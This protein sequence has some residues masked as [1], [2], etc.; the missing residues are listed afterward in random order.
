MDGF[1]FDNKVAIVTGGSSGMGEATARLMTTNGLTGA[2]LVG[3]DTERGNAVAADLTQAGCTSVFVAADLAEV[4]AIEQIMAAASAFERLDVLVNVAGVSD[5]NTLANA[6]TDFFDR[7]VAINVRA[8]YFLSQAA[9]ERMRQT[10]GGAIVNVGSVAGYAGEPKISVYSI[11]KAALR[12]MT[13]V[14]AQ[15]LRSDRIRVNQVNPG[16]SETPHEDRIQRTY[17]GAGDDWRERAG[18]QLPM[19]RLLNVD[20][21][22]RAIC[23]LASDASGIVTGSVFDFDQKVMGG[24]V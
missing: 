9:A 5:R 11:T 22:A 6:S 3:R 13:T 12:T 14:T 16:W 10:D 21:I 20:E 17:D 1:D 4:G 7:M 23:Y 2:V 8:P 18:E 15:E 24:I 19:G